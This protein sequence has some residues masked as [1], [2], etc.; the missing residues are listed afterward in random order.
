[1]NWY[2]GPGREHKGKVNFVLLIN[3]TQSTGPHHYNTT[4]TTADLSNTLKLTLL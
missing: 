4:S 2:L 3:V 1:M